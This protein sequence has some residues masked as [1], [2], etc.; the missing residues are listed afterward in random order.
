MEVLIYPIQVLKTGIA[1]LEGRR[2]IW[3]A[4]AIEKRIEDNQA[5]F[6]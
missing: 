1:I 3:K 2:I 6:I 4:N 5:Y